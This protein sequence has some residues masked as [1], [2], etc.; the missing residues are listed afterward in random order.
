MQIRS[1]RNMRLI[2]LSIMIT[3]LWSCSAPFVFADIE[4]IDLEEPYL[5]KAYSSVTG[6]DAGRYV[7]AAGNTIE[8]EF[9]HKGVV[10]SG[11]VFE[12]IQISEYHFSVG[13]T[14][15]YLI[16]FP[17]W[18]QT[19]DETYDV[20]SVKFFS[21]PGLPT[22]K[23]TTTYFEVTVFQEGAGWDMPP[24]VEAYDINGTF[25]G[26]VTAPSSEPGTNFHTLV[27]DYYDM[28]EIRLYGARRTVKPDVHG[29]NGWFDF[30]FETPEAVIELP[31]VAEAGEDSV[32]SA[33]EEV[34]LDA[35]S[36][37]SRAGDIVSYRWRRLPD[38]YTLYEG[39]KATF[40]TRALGRTEEVIELM[41]VD[42]EGNRAFDIV[43]IYLPG[44]EGPEGPQG[45][46]GEP[47]PIGPEGP[48][49]IQGEPGLTGP[50]GPQG[51][52]GPIGPAGP[53][54]EQ[55]EVG[56]I[57]PEGPQGE[58]GE[59][60][61]IG[62]AG[63]QG[64]QGEVGPIGP[65]GPQGV[66]G[67]VGPIGPEG[68]QGVQGEVGPIGPE[69][70]HGEVGP[71]GPEGPHGEVGPIGPEGPQGVQ[72]EVG[73]IGPAGPQGEQGEVGP[74]GPEGP[75]GPQG[76]PGPQ[77]PAGVQ[78]PTGPQGETG[79]MGP[80]GSQG[81]PGPQGEKGEQGEKGD[82]GISPEEL[83]AIIQDIAALKEEVS[84]LKEQVS[85]YEN[86]I[87]D[88]MNRLRHRKLLQKDFEKY[89]QNKLRLIR[90]KIRSHR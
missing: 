60:G 13:G 40:L 3:L 27:L 36:S 88:F 61:P 46:Q 56:P 79:P 37:H 24:Y 17:Y 7:S 62:P 19:F 4:Q 74:I 39:A 53:Q 47:G 5:N 54:G 83:Q 35:R 73:P 21:P 26:S 80:E 48:Q 18:N 66:Q 69:G 41:T 23:A 8:T 12:A 76:A 68:P 70:P 89:L 1:I 30:K 11:L 16:G 52:V 22:H 85:E 49:G 75:Q 51:E 2:V 32:A 64:E 31:I 57:G 81:E 55:G 86:F 6:D 67:E 84:A 77:G 43:R 87:D 15:K 34:L 28:H 78:G 50:E 59:V 44:V 72:G 14:K 42:S 9:L 82:P 29:W 63:P 20:V 90:N 71:I 45:P 38:F 65:E 33:D 58:Q 10:F 25:I